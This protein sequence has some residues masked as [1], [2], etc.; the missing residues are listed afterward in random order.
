MFAF[1]DS[2]IFLMFILNVSFQ[3]CI[4]FHARDIVVCMKLQYLLREDTLM[5]QVNMYT[6]INDT[7]LHTNIIQ[8]DILIHNAVK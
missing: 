7:T 8:D 2:G 3:Y 4:M 5:K 1:Q 6:S